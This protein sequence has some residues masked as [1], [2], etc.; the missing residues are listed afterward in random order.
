MTPSEAVKA[1]LV[2]HCGADAARIQAVHHGVDAS[3][4]EAGEDELAQ[5]RKRYE[6]PE[7]FVLV[8][9]SDEPRKNLVRLL[10]AYGRLPIELR[11]GAPL[12]IVGLSGWNNA[13]IKRAIAR[14]GDVRAIGFVARR[15]LPAVY[16]SATVFAFPSRYEGFGMPLLEAMAAG[17]PVVSSD[18][19]AMPEVVGEAGLLVDP[20]DVEALTR[21]LERMLKDPGL[22][23]EL[24]EAGRLRAREFTWD[25]TA[26]R[27]LAFL[28]ETWKRRNSIPAA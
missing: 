18:R 24:S 9:G 17:V 20:D 5:A 16:H 22:R 11:R 27:T 26:R 19:S 6:L 14:A 28:E 3:F 23:A 4:F 25:N 8:V 2:R 13:E 10:D 15:L 7:R 1:D 21:A 12:V